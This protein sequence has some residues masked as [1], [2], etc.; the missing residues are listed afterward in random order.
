MFD[1]IDSA[2]KTIIENN[3]FDK[4]DRVIVAVSGGPDSIALLHVLYKL[5]EE[6]HISLYVAHINHG[7]RGIESDKDEEYVGKV[8]KD[9]NIEFRSKKVDINEISRLRN[10]SSESA[11]REVRYEFFKELVKKFS[12]QKV[13]IAHNANDQAETILMRIMRGTGMDGLIG[14]RP[15]RDNIFVRPLINCTRNEIE[16]YC[17]ENKLNPRIDKTN[18]EAIY[19]RNKVRLQLIPYIQENFNK[20]IIQGLNRLSDTIKIDNDYIEA[21]SKEKYKKYCDTNEEKVII[22]KE[23]FL[24]HESIITRIIRLAIQNLVG[25]LYN[26]ERIHIYDIIRIQ[27]CSTGKELNLPGNVYSINNYGDIVITR[28]KKQNI[29]ARS[30]EYILGNGVNVIEDANIKVGIRVVNVEEK[31]DFKH[32]KWIKY[33][34]YDKIKGDITLRFRRDGDR[35]TP[36]GMSGSKKLKDLFIDLKIPKEERNEIPLICFGTSIAW[37]TGYR[38]SEIF[39]VDENTKNILEVKIEREEF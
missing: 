24:E 23:A 3:M 13:A 12:A 28:D 26:F 31:T 33:F 16:Q 11:G 27:R 19:S 22:S 9:L 15:V 29:K 25:N 32:N 7:L 39:K 6:L 1:L 20:D 4:G 34:D 36:L 37:I 8:C 38:V 35:F 10:M 2:L 17:L 18:L 30:E 21:I 14:I 5:K